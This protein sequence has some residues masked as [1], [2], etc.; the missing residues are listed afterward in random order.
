M[1]S[2]NAYPRGLHPSGY[3]AANIALLRWID[4]RPAPPSAN[5]MSES[6]RLVLD[7]LV[8]NRFVASHDGQPIPVGYG[9]GV[10]FVVSA[11]GRAVLAR[12]AA[13]EHQ[14]IQRPRPWPLRN[15]GVRVVDGMTRCIDGRLFEHR[16]FPDDPDYEHDAGPRT[17]ERCA[18]KG[19]CPREIACNE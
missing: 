4:A 10:R 12:A 11:E 17:P 8:L 2:T 6:G 18:G 14:I 7:G 15:R 3:S 9:V 13:A 19:Y 1:T 5:D 16:P